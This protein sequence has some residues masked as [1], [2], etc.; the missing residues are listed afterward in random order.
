MK[1]IRLLEEESSNK[2]YRKPTTNFINTFAKSVDD[3]I[4]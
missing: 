2:R 1:V 3:V 4:T